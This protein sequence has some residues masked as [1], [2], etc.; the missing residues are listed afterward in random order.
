MIVVNDA[1]P[2]STEQLVRS[3]DRRLSI[4]YYVFPG[5]KNGQRAGA[6]RNFGV[7]HAQGDMLL[8]L[9]TDIV[10]DPD[11]VEAH[12]SCFDP[13][14]AFF[15]FRRH[16]P[17][18]LV[19]PF[20]PPLDYADLYA[21]SVPDKRLFGY[22]RWAQPSYYLHFFGCNYSVPADMFCQLGGH[23][24]R[25]CGWGGEDIDL[26]YRICAI[27]GAVYPLWGMGMGTHLDHLQ[28]P[29]PAGEQPWHCSP[30]EPVCRNGGVLKRACGV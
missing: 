17:I 30:V 8:F 2:D 1:G 28:R 24:E 21:N 14:F 6:T 15:G 23:D 29:M 9:D 22:S 16:Y 5:P 13:K 26:G 25:Y 11:L 19:R 20:S 18:D 7:K 10:P 27:G 3:F 4:E 12:V